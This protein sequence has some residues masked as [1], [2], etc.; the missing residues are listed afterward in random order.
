LDKLKESKMQNT[1]LA[2]AAAA[3]VLAAMA[4]QAKADTIPYPNVGT[5]NP[6]SYT[7]TAASTGPLTVYEYATSGAGDDETVGLLVNGTQLGGMGLPDHSSVAGNSYTFGPVT[8]GDVLTFF[9]VDS[10]TGNTWYSDPSMNG[11]ENHIYSAYYSGGGVGVPSDVPAG[12]YI[13]FEDT[14]FATSDL[15]YADEQFVFANTVSTDVPT[16]EPAS[17]GLMGAGLVALSRVRGRKRTSGA[18]FTPA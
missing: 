1:K 4:T 11:G 14:A 8:Q 10:T 5:P 17:L 13:G 9:I 7:F 3:L 15:N 12:I 2:V 18:S 6:T 16:P